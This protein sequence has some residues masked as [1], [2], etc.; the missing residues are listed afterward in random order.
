LTIALAIT[1]EFVPPGETHSGFWSDLLLENRTPL[2]SLVH[3]S[4]MDFSRWGKKDE[5]FAPA[6]DLVSGLRQPPPHAPSLHKHPSVL[7]SKLETP[8][9]L[10][11][12]AP[13]AEV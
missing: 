4:K 10:F 5:N 2:H 3:S 8:R 9:R 1:P 6:A 13:P 12:K 11:G 7:L